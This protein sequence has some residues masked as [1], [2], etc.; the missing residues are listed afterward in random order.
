MKGGINMNNYEIGDNI[1]ILC[2]K[3]NISRDE[4]AERIGKSVRQVS[5]Y[6]NGGCNMNLE[7]LY[8]IANALEVPVKELF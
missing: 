4:L 5:R 6:C 7:I 2:K 8:K 1:V 3:K